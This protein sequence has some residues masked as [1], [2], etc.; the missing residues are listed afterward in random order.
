MRIA[1]MNIDKNNLYYGE[2]RD[3]FGDIE[4]AILTDTQSDLHKWA[5][6]HNCKDIKLIKETN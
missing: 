2:I 5:W 6:E 3:N 4:A 1:T